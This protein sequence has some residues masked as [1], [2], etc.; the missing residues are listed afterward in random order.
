MHSSTD[1]CPSGSTAYGENII[2]FVHNLKIASSNPYAGC[3]IIGLQE[4]FAL[5]VKVQSTL[6]K[7]IFFVKGEALGV[8]N[9]S[10]FSD[11]TSSSMDNRTIR[12]RHRF[13]F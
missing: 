1:F 13:Y 5:Q 4:S 6:A 7:K 11:P 10:F 12:V 8:M 2:T 9:M 3:I